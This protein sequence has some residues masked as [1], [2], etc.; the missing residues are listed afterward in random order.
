MRRAAD[1]P[2]NAPL[3]AVDDPRRPSFGRRLLSVVKYTLIAVGGL[4]VFLIVVGA[5]VAYQDQPDATKKTSSQGNNFNADFAY[6]IA[7]E[8]LPQPEDL[9]GS[10][11]KVTGTNDFSEDDGFDGAAGVCHATQQRFD[12][13]DALL[14]ARRS[15]RANI[16]ISRATPAAGGSTTTFRVD[17][18]V[19]RTSDD[20]QQVL[21]ILAVALTSRDTRSCIEFAVT[22][23]RVADV[24]TLISPPGGGTAVAYL[25]TVPVDGKTLVVRNEI[26]V[27][28]VDNAMIRLQVSGEPSEVTPALVEA[29]ASTTASRLNR[30]ADR[31]PGTPSPSASPTSAR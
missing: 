22:N 26:Y 1:A 13:A 2:G 28:K 11:W 30:K 25:I 20:L 23:A 27:W 3:I 5:I 24:A 4:G 21:D 6:H 7:S 9:P 8:S 10:G 14:A 19:Y 18:S 17:V 16:D 15:G 31:P 12:E 29:I